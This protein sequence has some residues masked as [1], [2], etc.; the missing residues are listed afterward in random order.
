MKKKTEKTKA[1]ETK[2]TEESLANFMDD[3]QV[4]WQ[5]FFAK[6]I[7]AFHEEISSS[8]FT[9]TSFFFDE[10]KNKL[11]EVWSKAIRDKINNF[12]QNM[13]VG[14]FREYQE[15][16]NRLR[17]AFINW[18]ASCRDFFSLLNLPLEESW[19]ELEREWSVGE[20]R[21]RDKISPDAIFHQWV[22]ILERYYTALYESE[23]FVTA[24]NRTLQHSAELINARTAIEDDFLKYHHLPTFREMDD[25]YKELYFLRK[26]VES[27]EK[28]QKRKGK[29]YGAA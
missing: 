5:D 24:M 3:F 17:K 1:D 27:L 10:T 19:K 14:P 25:L 2:G 16:N 12:F 28:A 20:M 8:S 22:G 7:R 13:A 9:A 15:K 21:S 23:E 18:E 6:Q 11:Y 29:S 4:F 26:R